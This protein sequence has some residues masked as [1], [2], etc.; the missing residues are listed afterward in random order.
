M[1]AYFTVTVPATVAVGALV[2]VTLSITPLYTEALAISCTQWAF[3]ALNGLVALWH[4]A[5]VELEMA[6]AEAPSF[7]VVT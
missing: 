1:T 2:S 4:E 5:Q 3:S 6:S 7:S